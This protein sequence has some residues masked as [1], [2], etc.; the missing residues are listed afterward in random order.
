MR[1]EPAVRF[2]AK[3]Q[4]SEDCWIWI[5][6]R[7]KFG[8][9]LFWYGSGEGHHVAHRWSWREAHGPVPP[10]L[11]LDH[12]CKN[13]S[14]V[15]PD[16]LE[17]VTR[18]ENMRR[19]TWKKNDFCRYGHPIVELPHGRECV[20]CRRARSALYT[21]KRKAARELARNLLPEKGEH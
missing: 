12:L 16:H 1:A 19:A 2:W 17:P 3:V 14:C 13:K 21:A 8:Y 20:T 10:G 9:G 6:C 15:R 4:R 5:G 18:S 7:N 11:E